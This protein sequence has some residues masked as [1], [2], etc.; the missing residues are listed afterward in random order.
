MSRHDRE[1]VEC[2]YAPGTPEHNAF[3]RAHIKAS[4]RSDRAD[5]GSQQPVKFLDPRRA[6]G[7]FMDSLADEPDLMVVLSMDAG[8]KVRI[9][10]TRSSSAVTNR[11]VLDLIDS[12]SYEARGG[13][14]PKTLEERVTESMA[15]RRA[16]RQ[17]E[18]DRRTVEE[19]KRPHVCGICRRRY[20]TQG[21]LARHAASSGHKP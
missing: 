16:R 4:S 21:W 9:L 12:T 17:V 3:V 10:L 15:R 11:D 18:R 14:T 19:A 6:A 7:N 5:V 20:T 8:G 13:R 1:V 2:P